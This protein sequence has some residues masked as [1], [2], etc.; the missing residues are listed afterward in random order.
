M[1]NCLVKLNI[2]SYNTISK[3]NNNLVKMFNIE[4]CI[5]KFCEENERAT[6]FDNFIDDSDDDIEDDDILGPL[7]VL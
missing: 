2:I 4:E 1:I 5:D 6:I 7:D 3:Y